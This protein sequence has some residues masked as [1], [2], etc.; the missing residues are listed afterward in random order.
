ML[1][2]K[3]AG[4]AILRRAHL[5]NRLPNTPKRYRNN[6]TQPPKPDNNHANGTSIPVPNTIAAVPIWQRFGP[7]SRGFEAYGRSQKKRPLTTQFWSALVIFFLGDLSAQSITD[8]DYNPARS[9][10]ALAIG[11]CA[12]IPSYKWFL[13]LGNNFNYSSKALSLATKVVVNQA[14]F[15]PINNSYFFGMQSLLCGD[16]LPEIWERI[17]RT[18]PPSMVNSLKLWPAVTAFNFTFIDPH[19]RSIFAGVIAIG[20]QTYLSFLNRQAE[21]EEALSKS[22]AGS[23]IS[24]TEK[25]MRTIIQLLDNVISS[26]PLMLMFKN[27][28]RHRTVALA[29][30]LVIGLVDRSCAREYSKLLERLALISSMNLSNYP[31]RWVDKSVTFDQVHNAGFGHLQS[32]VEGLL[33]KSTFIPTLH[34]DGPLRLDNVS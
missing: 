7:L 24:E 6:A 17:K 14:I 26:I 34:G 22:S 10:R 29:L 23:D 31:M 11:A 21:K 12:S 15:T 27:I 28:E 4:R 19:F 20:W 18:V 33:K 32:S 25:E 3:L 9:M 13:F 16:S 5:P 1:A 8:E 2:T 30:T